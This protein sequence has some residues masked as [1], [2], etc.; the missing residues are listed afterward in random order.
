MSW[1]LF[2][3]L[4]HLRPLK[5]EAELPGHPGNNGFKEAAGGAMGILLVIGNGLAATVRPQP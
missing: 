1:D 4:L 5:I 3:P 2:C